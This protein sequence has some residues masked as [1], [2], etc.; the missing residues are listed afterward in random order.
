MKVRE[1]ILESLSSQLSNGT[2]YKYFGI[3]NIEI[4]T[5]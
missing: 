3:P 4:H 5:Y 1:D 2:N